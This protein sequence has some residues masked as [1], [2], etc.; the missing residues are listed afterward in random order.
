MCETCQDIERHIH[1]M[2]PIATTKDVIS[3]SKLLQL[4]TTLVDGIIHAV[5]CSNATCKYGPCE[6]FKKL[7]A[8]VNVRIKESETFFSYLLYVHVI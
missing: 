5:K 3:Q 2:T 7:K 4:K 8:H 6:D 1:D